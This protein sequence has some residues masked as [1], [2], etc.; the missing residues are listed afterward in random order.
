MKL[1]KPK[2]TKKWDGSHCLDRTGSRHYV[3][4]RLALIQH[5]PVS[6]LPSAAIIDVY[7]YSWPHFFLYVCN[8]QLKLFGLKV[9]KSI[10]QA[11]IQMD[12][13]YSHTKNW[14][15]ILVIDI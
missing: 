5:S 3:F 6:N 4:P 7:F 1:K 15:G 13:Q 2:Q 14:S 10:F 9:N 8:N 11:K 12:Q